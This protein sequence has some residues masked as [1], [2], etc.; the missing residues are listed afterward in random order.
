MISRLL[1]ISFARL[2]AGN[3]QLTSP[4]IV[5]VIVTESNVYDG[6]S[7]MIPIR[8]EVKEGYHIQANRV[9]DESLIPTTLEVND[10]KNIIIGRQEF[11]L[12]KKFQLEGTDTFLN[13]YDGEFQIKLFLRAVAKMQTGKYALKAKLRYQACDSRSCLFPKVIDFSI[14]LEVRPVK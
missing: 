1:I 6:I 14:P 5:T 2:L 12:S 9:D 13:V 10:D 11:P 3:I 8:V 4:A 7:T